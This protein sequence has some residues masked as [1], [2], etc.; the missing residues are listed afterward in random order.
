M[1]AIA[2]P[3]LA[4]NELPDFGQ[5]SADHVNPA[6]DT[7]LE[8]YRAAVAALCADPGARDFAQLMAP[9]ELLEERLSRAFAPVAHLH[10]VKDSP[11]LREAY[12]K[13]LEKITQFH[14]DLGQN[15]ALYEAVQALH[16]APPFHSLDRARQTL[17]EDSLRGFR[18]SGVALQEPARSRFAQ[19][20]NALSRLETAFE[21]AVLDATDSWHKPL[22]TTELAGFPDSALALLAQAAAEHDLPG[23]AATLKGPVVQAILT[24]ADDRALRAEVYRAYNT[25]ASDQGPSAGQYD[26]SEN[27]EQI[28]ALRHEAAQLLGF[29]SAA[30]L[31]V[32][33][34]MAS[35]PQRVLHFLQD[36]ATRAKPVAERELAELSAYAA[37]ELGLATLEPWDVAWAAEKL[38]EQRYAFS[39]EEIKPYFPLPAVLDGMLGIAGDVFDL[40]FR[41][42]DGVS[43]WHPDVRYYDVLAADGSVLAG[44]YLDLYARAS[45]RG[46]AWMDVCRA[47]LRH[48]GALQH[49]VAFLTCNFAPP[50]GDRPALLTHDDV[51]TLFHEFGHGLHHMLTEV[52]W[53]GIGGIAGV[54]WDAVE[55]PSQFMENFGWQREALDRFARH[56]QTGAT[57][58]AEL[59]AK[60]TA[61]RHYHAGLFLLRQL[62]YALFDFRL[63]LEFDPASGA[64]ALPLLDVIRRE[65]AVLKPPA[66]HRFPHAFTHVF[67][68]GYAAGYYS[69]LWAEVLSADAFAAFEEAGIF[70]RETGERYR[71]EILAVGGSRPAL[72]SFLAFRGREPEPAALLRSYGLAA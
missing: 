19:I 63:H 27:I 49:P 47:R 57:L 30:H 5:I 23:H 52:D 58:P 14:T 42:R 56:H 59:F 16:D 46:G 9:L 3:L 54:E 67:A 50:N 61:A 44:F 41:V 72:E 71:R 25:R 51:L 6:I 39:E 64:R 70:D 38:R 7:V 20:Q 60:M 34:K 37:T 33:D 28:M 53:P 12:A 32:T 29:A 40:H 15:R 36:L 69:Y 45:K 13:A 22:A 11:E 17:V 43:V 8:Q 31:S 24:Y 4:H 2:N 66:W 48:D 1:N 62:E 65:V 35:S 55:L 26:N 21:E 18:L 10:G 68:G